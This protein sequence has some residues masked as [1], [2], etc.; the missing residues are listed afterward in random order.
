V[1]VLTVLSVYI[2]WQKTQLTTLALGR[3]DLVP[4]IR[5]MLEEKRYAAAGDYLSFSWIMIMSI[6]IQRPNS[7]TKKFLK[8]AVVGSISYSS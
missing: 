6:K 8:N 5:L 3:I 4:K 2:I 7:Y 1:L